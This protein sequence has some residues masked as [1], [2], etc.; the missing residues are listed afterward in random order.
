M[1]SVQGE[2]QYLSELQ[3]HFDL[4]VPLLG[5]YLSHTPALGGNDNGGVYTLPLYL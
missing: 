1:T 2:W 4:A 5:I 3:R